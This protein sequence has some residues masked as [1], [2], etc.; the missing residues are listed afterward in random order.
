[1]N[2]T[3]EFPIRLTEELLLLMLNEHSGYLETVPGWDFSCVMAG[4]VI[5]DLA[6]AN[7]IDTDL[8]SLYLVDATPTGDELLD[9]TLKDI[10]EADETLETQYWVERNTVRSEDIVTTTLERLVDKG[11]LDYES[12]GFWTLSSAVSRSRMYPTAGGKTRAE[13]KARVLDVVLNDT[14]PDPR[15]VILVSL[16]HTCDGFKQLLSEE[17]YQEKLGRIELV[18][19][20][21]LLG[22]SVS[23]AVR[24]ST[25]R[26]KTRRVVQTKPIPKLRF[27]DILRQRDL[28]AGNI[29]KAMCGIFERH[30]PVVEL[31]FKM[32]GHPIVALMGQE[33]NQWVHRNGRFYLRSKDYIKD[34]EAVLGASRTLPGM[35]G[36]EHHKLRRSLRSAYSRATLEQR[37]PELI[38]HCRAS[39]ARWQEGEVLRATKSFQNHVSSQVSD[40]AMG[41]SCSHYVDELL[42]F[43]HRALVTHVQGALPKFMLST[44]KMK[45]AR[46]RVYE[47]LDAIHTSHTPAQRKGKPLDIADAVLELHRNDPQFLPETDITFPFVASMVAS[48]YLGSALT[49]AVYSMIRHPELYERVHREAQ[50][51]FGNGHEP[52][53][54]DFSLNNIGVTQ[55]LFLESERLHPV[56]PWQLRTVMNQCI[57]N[58]FEIPPQ[59]WVLI[60]Q[61]VPHYTETVF[62]DPLT[63]DIDRYLPERGEHLAPGAYAPYG[64]GTHTCLGRRWVE[65]QMTVNLLLIAYHLQLEIV[66]ANYRLGINP[67]P[68][69]APNSKLKFRV[70]RITNPV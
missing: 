10:G 1:M 67:F 33:V 54:E 15:D 58:G 62:K 60:C 31:P 14:I 39:I 52:G 57:I 43:E 7:R 51:L 34:F 59:T 42:A 26:P 66:P 13:A 49:F 11:I 69:S 3:E 29:P 70:A 30:G 65:L 38:S 8:T 35:D 48:I 23:S 2:A 28:L 55:R 46:K 47:L 25:V 40:L 4:A 5:A 50:A 16:M 56:I 6:L 53:I 63:F 45:R 21:D 64:L 44:P 18:A 19:R 20:M 12:G 32:R 27:V 22:L 24:Q 61:T 17:D 37:L 68:T 41:V 36:A 9:P